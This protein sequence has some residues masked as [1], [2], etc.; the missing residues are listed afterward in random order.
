MVFEKLIGNVEEV[1]CCL[2]LL[3]CVLSM[4]MVDLGF[5]VVKKYDLEV[6]ILSYNF[7][8]EI[9]FCSNFESF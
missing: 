3:Y 6:W 4:C 9:F 5:I 8:C 2:E 7:Y 1:L